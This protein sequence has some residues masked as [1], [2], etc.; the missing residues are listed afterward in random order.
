[1]SEWSEELWVA[2]N[3]PTFLVIFL[4]LTTCFVFSPFFLV[5]AILFFLLVDASPATAPL[6]YCSAAVSLLALLSVTCSLLPALC[7]SC[8][9]RP[10]CCDVYS[11]YHV[12]PVL[13]C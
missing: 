10:V 9:V 4:S 8:A 1:M 12:V 2:T 13:F 11:M 7:L 6:R 5:G 3:T